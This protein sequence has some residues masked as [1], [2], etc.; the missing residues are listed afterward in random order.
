L[1][2]LGDIAVISSGHTFRS[3]IDEDLNGNYTVIQVKDFDE[4]DRIVSE[5]LLKTKIESVNS[6][7]LAKSG[8]IL[9]RSR[10]NSTRAS[11]VND[12]IGQ[13]CVVASPI[14]I[15]RIDTNN[16]LPEYVQLVI[17]HSSSQRYFSRAGQGSFVNMID[18]ETL[19]NLM[20]PSKSIADQ[21]N[22]IEL[23]QL[24]QTEKTLMNQ[25][26]SKRQTL[27]EGVFE[28]ERG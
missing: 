28:N 23:S 25:I 16:F 12:S 14:L 19:A 17:N 4:D 20:I 3:R 8:D 27:L 7:F 13:H 10:G 1:K 6:K 2:K 11:L 24:I 26:A 5:G 21:K 22:V 15:I 18:K 9:F